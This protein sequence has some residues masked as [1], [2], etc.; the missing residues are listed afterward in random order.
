MSEKREKDRL[1]RLG[2]ILIVLGV[3]VWG[4]YAVLRFGMGS[5]AAVRSFLP[6]HLAGVVPGVILKR[7]RF[8]GNIV[9]RLWS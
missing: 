2:T 9:K 5:D 7:H 1:E 3:A 8:F 4:V 6:Y